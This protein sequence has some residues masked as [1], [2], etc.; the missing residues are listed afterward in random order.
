MGLLIRL[1]K[2]INAPKTQLLQLVPNLRIIENPTATGM[3][4]PRRPETT[5]T[6]PSVAN[7]DYSPLA[8]V[9]THFLKPARGSINEDKR[10]WDKNGYNHLKPYNDLFRVN[11]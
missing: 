8:S 4:I 1:T 6:N 7:I 11:R 2:N 3:S 5:K 9:R 10:Y